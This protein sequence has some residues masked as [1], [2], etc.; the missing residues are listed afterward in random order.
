M[1]I[2]L[3]LLLV[4]LA[5]L[6]AA[7]EPPARLVVSVA[8]GYIA[9]VACSAMF[10][11]GR[12][13]E[14]VRA[15]ELHGVFSLFS[16]RADLDSRSVTA[17]LPGGLLAATAALRPGGAAGLGCSLLPAGADARKR[18]DAADAVSEELARDA[19][20]GGG[21]WPDG[22]EANATALAA[23]LARVDAAAMAAA[24]DDAFAEQEGAPPSA[25]RNTRAVVVLVDG[26]IVAER[27]APGFTAESR[28]AGWSMTKSMGNALVGARVLEGAMRLDTP[29]SLGGGSGRER[30][31]VDQAL[32]MSTGL[33]FD[34]RYTVVP[35]DPSVMLFTRPSAADYAAAKPLEHEPDTHW[36]Y[37][38]GTSNLL[39]RALRDSYAGDERA[40]LAAPHAFFR[41]VGMRSALIETDA[42]GE[43]VLSSFGW[44][45]ARD[46]A[47]FGLL[48]Q[49]D[50]VWAGRERVLPEGWSGYT[51]RATPASDGHYGAHWWLPGHLDA[52][53][54]PGT[55]AALPADLFYANGFE[56][57]HVA[58]SQSHRTVVVRLGCTRVTKNFSAARLFKAVFGA[59][60]A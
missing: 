33:E 9:K 35:R 36:S 17:S 19:P 43:H 8:H 12:T 14:S 45:T 42:G 34:E 23:A 46:W 59:V 44:A 3:P 11:G 37:S 6:L 27:Y 38:S 53:D 31:T 7:L 16:W 20:S 4:A 41:R 55:S 21:V 39:S 13:E 52:A 50:G 25:L 30:L 1:R 5:A 60:R 49:N 57:Q 47:R 22:D 28:L 15:S 32:R 48:Y 18:P 40:Y 58:V 56:Q 54:E 2:S 51:R 24:L 26:Q 29:L 10:V